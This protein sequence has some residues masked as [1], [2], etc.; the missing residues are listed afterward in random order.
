VVLPWKQLDFFVSC[1]FGTGRDVRGLGG[2]GLMNFVLWS[3][4]SPY[5]QDSRQSSYN[6]IF[7]KSFIIHF[8]LHRSNC[9]MFSRV[10]AQNCFQVKDRDVRHMSKS[11]RRPC[12][13]HLC[14]AT[15]GSRGHQGLL[16]RSRGVENV[17]EQG[18][19]SV[20]KDWVLLR[21]RQVER[22]TNIIL[23]HV[24]SFTSERRGGKARV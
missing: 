18:W 13:R 2:G 11:R 15:I 22:R 23:L 10:P 17:M 16:Q 8:R 9:N 5:C 7:I 6:T 19:G 4:K 20:H 21:S 3:F 24:R 14:N 1:S 12:S